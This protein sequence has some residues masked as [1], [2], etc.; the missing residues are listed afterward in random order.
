MGDAQDIAIRVD[1]WLPAAEQAELQI[2]KRERQKC[3]WLGL[4]FGSFA[5]TDLARIHHEQDLEN[6]SEACQ[7]LL[8]HWA[9]LAV[10]LCDVLVAGGHEPAPKLRLAEAYRPLA[11]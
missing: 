2:A 10:M 9:S 1:R 5:D 4:V 6:M 8:R 11:C 3:G 7:I